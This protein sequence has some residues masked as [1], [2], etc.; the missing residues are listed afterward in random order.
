MRIAGYIEHPTLKITI[1]QYQGKY[2]LKLENSHFEETFKLREELFP[3]V[4]AVRALVT[5]D[6]LEK[7][8]DRFTQMSKQMKMYLEQ[9]K[10]N[11]NTDEEEWP[12]IY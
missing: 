2:S 11:T 4:E 5:N 12:V 6:F 1:F 8:Q 10:I 3:S 9:S 7:V